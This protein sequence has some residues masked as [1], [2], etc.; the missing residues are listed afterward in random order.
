M[1]N[2]LHCILFG[3]N[4]CCS[5][6][7]QKAVASTMPPFANT[8]MPNTSQHQLSQHVRP[9]LSTPA[10]PSVNT[11]PGTSVGMSR[12]PP[13]LITTVRPGGPVSSYSPA[14]PTLPSRTN[15]PMAWEVVPPSVP[16]MPPSLILQQPSF[17]ATRQDDKHR[18]TTPAA[19][20]PQGKD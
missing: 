14:A 15:P 11:G 3:F 20:E 18:K 10:R 2:W 16:F 5:L 8:K 6:C 9:V 4:C 1:N 12:I 17:S 19:P 7:F 13:S